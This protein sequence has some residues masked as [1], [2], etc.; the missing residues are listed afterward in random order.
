MGLWSVYAG[1]FLLLLRESEESFPCSSVGSLPRETVL[2]ELLH[3]ESIPQE[4]FSTNFCNLS[5]KRKYWILHW[6][7]INMVV[8]TNQRKRVWKATLQNEIWGTGP[9]ANWICCVLITKRASCLLGCIRHSISSWLREIIVPLHCRPTSSTECSFGGLKRSTSS[10]W[11]VS[12]G[13]QH[14]ERPW[15]QDL[16]GA[17]KVTWFAHL[18]EGWVWPY[19]SLQLSRGGQQRGRC[20]SPL[21]SVQQQDTR[22]WNKAA[23][24]EFQIGD[25]SLGGLLVTDTGFPREML[26]A[27][28][29]REFKE[30]LD[31]LVIWF[32][33]R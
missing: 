30:Y 18:R 32:S 20:W 9:V 22:K 14:G 4:Q 29:P 15:E 31:D 7:Q 26:M 28:S 21:S 19:H 2:Y 13:N 24:G 8:R 1:L 23:P 33:F 27:L 17:S 12:T 16:W 11:T 25:Y 6:G 5:H 10:Y 3:C